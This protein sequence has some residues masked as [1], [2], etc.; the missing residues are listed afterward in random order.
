MPASVSPSA[1]VPESAIPLVRQSV[2]QSVSSAFPTIASSSAPR[3]YFVIHLTQS[4]TDPQPQSKDMADVAPAAEAQPAVGEVPANDQQAAAEKGVIVTTCD[5]HEVPI[6]ASHIRHLK[7]ISDMLKHLPDEEGEEEV[8]KVPMPKVGKAE[9]DIILRWTAY[10]ADDPDESDEE[11]DGE[12]GAAEQ[13]TRCDDIPAWDVDFIKNLVT[14]DGTPGSDLSKLYAV[15]Q[16]CNYL[17]VKLLLTFCCKFVAARLKD[18]TVEEARLHFHI[19][20]DYSP[21]EEAQ[22]KIDN[23]WAEAP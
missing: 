10:H 19:L 8:T 5:G 15:M 12:D 9:L 11:S 21:E 2:S 22:L 17:D 23:A 4:P 6:P 16:A 13:D 3:P 14:E 20:N 7:I 18:L 1:R